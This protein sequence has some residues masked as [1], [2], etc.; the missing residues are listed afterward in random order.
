M[1]NLR[2]L[3]LSFFII[4]LDQFSKWFIRNAVEFPP[5]GS[6]KLTPSFFWITHVQNHGAAFGISPAHS[7]FNRV[8][9][10]VV[11]IVVLGLIIY[12]LRKT[13]IK[14]ER[15]SYALIIGGAIGNLID[16]IVLGSVTDFLDFDFPNFIAKIWGSTR[17]P[18][19]NIADSAIVIAIIIL[20]AQMVLV[21][22]KAE[23]K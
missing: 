8:F 12:L 13:N 1:R 15:V 3:W 18:V 20:I 19:F 5:G 17:W 4:V 7:G 2:Y 23:E 6:I 10:S 21:R 16:R 11:T 9:F 22:N 14:T